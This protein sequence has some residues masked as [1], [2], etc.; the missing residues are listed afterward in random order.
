MAMLQKKP[1]EI[2]F[3]QNPQKQ[4]RPSST[5]LI[6]K[7]IH[8]NAES[9]IPK[10]KS[11]NPK[12][13]KYD[14]RKLAIHGMDKTNKDKANIDLLIELGAKPRSKRHC[15]IQEYQIMKKHHQKEETMRTDLER[16]IGVNKRNSKASRRKRHKDDL[17]K[18]V[19]GQAGF[20]KQGVQ[21]VKKL[22][23]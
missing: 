16:K 11:F 18:N 4:M 3:F 17:L 14:I 20:Y 5:V 13:A 8:K 9:E 21:F 23:R 7:K 15:P 6:K 22:K 10:I 2:V 1:V 12:Q 19:D